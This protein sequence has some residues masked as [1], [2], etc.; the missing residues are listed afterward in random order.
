[1]D[2]LEFSTHSFVVKVWLEGTDDESRQARWRGHITHVQSGRREY[3]EDLDKIRAFIT[4]Y[5]AD[6]GVSLGFYHRVI[7]W[8]RH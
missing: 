7:R 4:T 6:M 3:F 2:Q 1:M 5:L 8:L